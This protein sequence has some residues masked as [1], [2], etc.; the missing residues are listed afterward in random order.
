MT[1][2]IGSRPICVVGKIDQDFPRDHM[3]VGHELVDVV[4]RRG[5][6]F[7]ALEN[8]HVLGQACARAIKATIGASQASAFLTR[9]VLVRKRGSVIMSSRPIARNRRSAIAWID[10]EM[11]IYRPSLVRNT[12]RGEVVSERLPVR[13]RTVPVN[14]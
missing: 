8:F 11:P 4:D 2:C 13:S 12:L 6:D 1:L 3:R 5:G 7:G 14:R 9:S 10:A